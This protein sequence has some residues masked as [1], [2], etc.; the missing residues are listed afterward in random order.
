MTKYCIKNAANFYIANK[1]IQNVVVSVKPFFYLLLV[2]LIH[3][4][5]N[6]FEI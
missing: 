4:S 5:A 6:R 3:K 1:M 2:P